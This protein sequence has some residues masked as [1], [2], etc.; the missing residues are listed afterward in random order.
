MTCEGATS[1][2]TSMTRS[3]PYACE[4]IRGGGWVC[5][6]HSVPCDGVEKNRMLFLSKWSR[7]GP[8]LIHI[9][10]STWARYFYCKFWELPVFHTYKIGHSLLLGCSFIWFVSSLSLSF[11]SNPKTKNLKQWEILAS[12]E[13]FVDR[14]VFLVLDRINKMV[15]ESC[16]NM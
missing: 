8:Y 15:S 13:M 14:H 16:I 12:F 7:Y 6:V 10:L 11:K 9:E 2:N 3:V 4:C 5:C 1:F